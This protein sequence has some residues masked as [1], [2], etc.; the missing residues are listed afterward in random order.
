MIEKPALAATAETLGVQ[1]QLHALNGPLRGQVFTVDRTPFLLGK[2][3]TN[4]LVLAHNTVS[5][6]HCRLEI[7]AR[8]VRVRDLGSTNGTVVDGTPVQF[9]ELG[10]RGTLSVGA[11][12]FRFEVK[13][14]AA[15]SLPPRP[16]S[17]GPLVGRCAAMQSVFNA[18]RRL[19]ET[20]GPVAITG[21]EGSGRRT[22]AR[23]LL[24][25]SDE[26]SRRLRIASASDAEEIHAFATGALDV[27]GS[28]LLFADLH[29]APAALRPTVIEALRMHVS[30]LSVRRLPV[31]LFLTFSDRAPRAAAEFCGECVTR[32]EA[33]QLTLPSLANR[34]DDIPLLAEALL[35]RL[36]AAQQLTPRLVLSG[37]ALE[38]LKG[39]DYLQEVAGL[40]QRIRRGALRAIERQDSQL[41]LED[42]APE[43]ADA[44]AAFEASHSYRELK[45]DAEA[46]FE[47][48][49]VRWLL[50]RHRGNVSAAAR[51]AEMDRKYLHKL[52]KKHGLK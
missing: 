31:R 5:R 25:L 26:S 18:A 45:A 19:C 42:V 10:S 23:A 51:A 35:A 20:K 6:A 49:Y 36:C 46:R 48:S 22:L 33:A 34:R 29:L 28:G 47:R 39:A 37:E 43:I 50:G 41:V 3:P 15:D 4:D 52:A 17:F 40:E 38:W 16:E 11:L 9:R 32:I 27:S 1:C 7:E 12:D 30:G 8:S 14:H 44:G 21:P 24:S 13:G 2:A